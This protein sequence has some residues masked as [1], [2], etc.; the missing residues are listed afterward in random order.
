MKRKFTVLIV[1]FLL[2]S[3]C[4]PA[5]DDSEVNSETAEPVTSPESSPPQ[6][7]TAVPTDTPHPPTETVPATESQPAPTETATP[8]V[9]M[10]QNNV[11]SP[12]MKLTAICPSNPN[13]T[14]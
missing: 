6:S 10:A 5:E 9:R 3:G 12:R 2:L 13:R 1:L 11:Y 14:P 4:A 7:E 8:T